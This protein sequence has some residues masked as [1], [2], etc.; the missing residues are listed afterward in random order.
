MLGLRLRQLE[1]DP[2]V[3][4]WLLRAMVSRADRCLVG[5][6]GFHTAPGPA[7]LEPYSPGAVELG[8]TVFPP[9][10]RRGYARESCNTLIRW[11]R[12]FHGVTRFVMTIRPDNIASQS[13]AKSLGFI[14]IGSHIDDVDGLEDILEWDASAPVVD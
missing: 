5:Y 2:A 1:E 10:R 14:K 3:S 11:A 8:F 13:L 12:E 6:I 9:Y 7:Y 4:P